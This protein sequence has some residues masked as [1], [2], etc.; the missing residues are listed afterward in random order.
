MAAS[1]S[2]AHTP[3]PWT[4]TSSTGDVHSQANN[5]QKWI[6]QGPDAAPTYPPA[7]E[8]AANSRLIAAAPD[9]L[10]ELR[11]LVTAVTF[12]DPPKLFNGVLA[13]EAR[14]PV[15][16]IEAALAAISKARGQ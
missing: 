8:I 9:L 1:C 5:G 12:A 4:V 10:C 2:E 14:V 7:G 6:C 13:H 11:A 3:G 16:F 15:E